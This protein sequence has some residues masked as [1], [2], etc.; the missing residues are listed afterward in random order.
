MASANQLIA[1]LKSHIAGDDPRFYNVAM[2][3]AASEAKKGHTK[4]AK[5]M[6]T[7]VDEAK[8]QRS[9]FKNL[10]T[11]VPM[12]RPKGELANLMSAKYPKERLTDMFLSKELL[13][14]IERVLHEQRQADR[15][16]SFGLMPRHRLLLEGAPGSGKT[17]SACV[18][19]S[20]LGLPLFVIRLDTVITRYL[21]ETATKLRQVFDAIS[22]T[23]GVYL[24]D[25][26]DAIGSKR[27]VTNDV[28]EIR[29]VLNSFLQFLE[30]DSSNS[31]IIATT[32]HVELLDKALFRR[33][34]DVIHYELP[35]EDMIRQAIQ[36]RFSSFDDDYLEWGEIIEQ[37][38]GLSQADILKSCDEAI[39]TSILANTNIIQQSH[40][41]EELRNRKNSL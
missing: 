24:F 14:K 22:E 16:R 9:L 36:N 26:F 8:K 15:I 17:M 25:E 33:F 18:I 19:A 40:I 35:N 20:E 41:V 37:A 6:K 1:L 10:S 7:L 3:I 23:R 13:A 31:L 32:N 2:Q 28:G 11:P 30:E 34:D 21:G 29:R 39:K 5:E 12:V 38:K 27:A 4:V